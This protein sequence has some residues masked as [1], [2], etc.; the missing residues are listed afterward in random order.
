MSVGDKE[1]PDLALV[2][3]QIGD[4]RNHQ[5][6]AVHIVIREG[7]AAVHHNDVVAVLKGGDIHADLSKT[8]Q[9]DDLYRRT[10]GFLTSASPC[11]LY[12]GQV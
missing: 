10:I 8:A 6:H 1:A 7:Q 12:L 5:I 4:I 2:F 11:A 3:L 9:R